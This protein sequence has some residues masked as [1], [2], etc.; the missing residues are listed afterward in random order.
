MK[1]LMVEAIYPMD[2]LLKR[3]IPFPQFCVCAS[4]PDAHVPM[5]TTNMYEIENGEYALLD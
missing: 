3:V 4:C 2:I 5:P 1:H